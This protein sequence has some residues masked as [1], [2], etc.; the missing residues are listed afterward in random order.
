MEKTFSCRSRC[1]KE[2]AFQSGYAMFCDA[3]FCDADDYGLQRGCC[4]GERFTVIFWA[5]IDASA[6]LNSADGGRF[7]KG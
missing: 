3:E 2:E 1:K 5:A 7:P 4:F 6:L